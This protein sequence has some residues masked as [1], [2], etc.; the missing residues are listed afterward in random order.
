MI[1]ALVE[2]WFSIYEGIINHKKSA[3]LQSSTFSP[4]LLLVPLK[5]AHVIYHHCKLPEGKLIAKGYPLIST[6]IPQK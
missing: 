3:N 1:F 4:P 5:T 2:I 6:N